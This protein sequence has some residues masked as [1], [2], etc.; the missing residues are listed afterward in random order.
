MIQY[1]AQ[2]GSE[3]YMKNELKKLEQYFSKEE[4]HDSWYYEAL[5]NLHNKQN[6]FTRRLIKFDEK[7]LKL[8]K[9]QLVDQSIKLV[10][11]NMYS[12]WLA[13]IMR[14]LN[15]HYYLNIIEKTVYIIQNVDE[16]NT[17][18]KTLIN[19]LNLSNFELTIC[20]KIINRFFITKINLFN[21]DNNKENV[22]IKIL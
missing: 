17:F 16:N 1:T 4:L 18:N 13:F 12:K 8:S 11:P 9:F 19:E 15:N 5:Q 14:C 6:N 20:Q 10:E 21:I 7:N 22:I 2:K 3:I